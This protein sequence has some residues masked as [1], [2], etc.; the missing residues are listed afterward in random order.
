MNIFNYTHKILREIFAIALWTYV[1]TKMFIHNVDIYIDNLHV[2]GFQWI[3]E[4]QL[5]SIAI[6]ITLYASAFGVLRTFCSTFFLISY[7]FIVIPW[8]VI[9]ITFSISKFIVK[10]INAVQAFSIANTTFVLFKDL[11]YNLTTTVLYLAMFGTSIKT[12]N[13]P[14]LYVAAIALPI[15]LVVSYARR[16]SLVFQPTSL[17]SACKKFLTGVGAANSLKPDDTT[18][19]IS[20]SL[21]SEKQISQ[22]KNSLGL[23][24]IYNKLCLF[25]AK[26]LRSYQDSWVPVISGV[27]SI[28]WLLI[29]TITTFAFI[30]LSIYK[31]STKLFFFSETPSLFTFFYYSFKEFVFN[32][33]PQLIPTSHVS[34]SFEMAENFSALFLS[35]IFVFLALTV[36]NE[37]YSREVDNIIFILEEN[38]QDME[39]LIKER[40][41]IQDVN[42]AI[43]ELK[44]LEYGAIPVIIFLSS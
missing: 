37:R 9:L 36:K 6:T 12:N 42:E 8:R 28:I 16:V 39:N 22:R 26:N 27:I 11:R 30:N 19:G 32:T 44:R 35:I 38:G 20:I 15:M 33:I 10:K 18:L 21:L 1:A 40:Y 17:F 25:L 24:V 7:P 29:L 4:H 34:Q 3:L 5:V 43:T 2:S 23:S 14:L 31:I 13:K 41:S